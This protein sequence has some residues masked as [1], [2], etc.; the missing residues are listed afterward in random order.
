MDR[1]AGNIYKAARLRKGITQETA[2]EALG[3]STDSVRS[4]E[5][6]LSLI[7][8]WQRPSYHRQGA[9]GD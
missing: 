2:A 5:N 3:I 8:I 4:Y 1:N 7:H 9:A 6:G